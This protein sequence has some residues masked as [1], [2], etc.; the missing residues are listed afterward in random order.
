MN[1]ALIMVALL[2]QVDAPA[3]LTPAARDR[4]PVLTKVADPYDASAWALQDA[5]AL[6]AQDPPQSAHHCLYVWIGPDESPLTAKINSLV[7]NSSL[8]HSSTIQLP[9]LTAGGRLIRWDLRKLCPKPDDFHRL[10][11]VL[12]FL[13]K[14]EPYWNVDLAAL[15]LPSQKVAPFVWIDGKTYHGTSTVPAP[16]TAEAYQ[17]LQ[18]ETGLRAP[19]M[20]ADWFMSRLLR[21]VQGG[22]YYEAR[23]FVQHRKRL[24]ETEILAT[25][26]VSAEL[27]RNVGG[28]DR[29]GIVRSEV[30][31]Q[32]RA[33]E[34][35]QGAIGPVRMT[36]DKNNDETSVS[37]HPFYNLLDIVNRAN[38]KET[39]FELANGLQGYILTDGQGKLVDVA[40]SKLVTDNRV[41]APH[42]AE[43]FPPLSC[44]RCHA[45]TGGVKPCPNNVR[46]LLAGGKRGGL[47]VFADFA[48]TG[49]TEVDIDRLA[50]LYGGDF[51]RRLRDSRDRYGDAVFLATRG[52]TAEKAGNAVADAYNA[53]WYEPVTAERQLLELGWRARSPQAAK[54][55]LETLLAKAE[56]D[57]LIDGQKIARE[58]PMIH[59]PLLGLPIGRQ[60]AERIYAES[61][62]RAYLHRAEVRK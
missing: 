53:Y 59:A 14:S 33:V 10:L 19:L 34:A 29:V 55:A 13:A 57:L 32:P 20:R 58:D 42:Q 7:V 5:L 24:S 36:Y 30:T 35:I 43:L 51:D 23:G 39:I 38:G 26:G 27:S 40:P 11:G 22:V 49:F 4:E 56:S 16:A 52:L 15:G 17:L 44:I 41:P 12:N 48:G 60:D 1:W 50:G 3:A 9:E 61:F 8:S 45:S 31:A 46:T 6:K 47:D 37:R 2:A 21:T 25:L 62:R 54:Q 18:H 28:D